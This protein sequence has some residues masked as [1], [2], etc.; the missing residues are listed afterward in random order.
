MKKLPI[1]KI[2]T[3]LFFIISIISVSLCGVGYYVY[4]HIMNK[5]HDKIGYVAEQQMTSAQFL[6]SNIDYK[7]ERLKLVMFSRDFIKKINNKISYDEAFQ[8]AN[9]NVKWCE[10]YPTQDP[11]FKLALQWQESAFN[12][13]IVSSVG[14]RG[15]NQIMP[16]MAR[17]LCRGYG[18]EFKDKMLD[19]VDFNNRLSCQLFEEAINMYDKNIELVLACY[20]GGPR[21]VE[22]YRS[23]DERLVEETKNYIPVIMEKYNK[24]REEYSTYYL[25]IKSIVPDSSL[26]R[27]K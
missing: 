12:K 27:K 11:L 25:D 6:L 20:N 17:I 1:F 24:I 18:I 10:V 16:Y 26:I 23:K 7:T 5:I 14:A 2:L 9:S 19:D 21:Q 4:K 15:L 3:G 13:E 22:Y 8:I